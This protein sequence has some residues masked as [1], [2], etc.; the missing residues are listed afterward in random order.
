MDIIINGGGGVGEA[1]ADILS[2]EGHDV[3]I[4]ERDPGRSDALEELL[5]CQIINAT[6]SSPQELVRAKAGR[7]DIFLAVTDLDEV[8]LLSC[9]LARQ[10]GAGRSFARVSDPTYT[11]GDW[12]GRL[13]ELGIGQVINPEQ[14]AA[15]ET[16]RLLKTP[17]TTQLIPLAS[18]SVISAA[19]LV[20]EN[21]PLSGQT[22]SDLHAEHEHLRYRV[23]VIRRGNE[24][25]IPTGRDHVEAN[26]E[27]FFVA[28]EDT[29]RKLAAL[30][31]NKPD[32]GKINRVMVFGASDLG[33]HVAQLLQETFNVTLVDPLGHEAEDTSEQ[34]ARTLVIKGAGHEMDLLERVGLG[35][36]DAMVAVGDQ[37]EMNLIS[38]LYARRLGVRRTIARIERPFYRPL[39]TTVGV[40]A[41]VSARQ[42]TVNAILKYVRSGDIKAVARMRG[43]KAEALELVPGPQAKLIDVPLRQARFP[44][45]ALVAV[46]T[47][48]GEVIIPDG[49][50]RIRRGDHV[51]VFALEHVIR[52]VEKLFASER[53]S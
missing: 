22:L 5:D 33:R 34:L 41:A 43:I 53:G 4:I 11:A 1:L 37:E 20:P 18:G 8:N 51:V 47:R 2:L 16:V 25:I 29:I 12:P 7:C 50:T 27:L 31:T 38:C 3:T 23:V 13:S 28:Q 9:I 24:T 15:R 36:M 39:M 30:V 19:V 14:E 35:E 52:K 6:G 42:A 10:M 32:A 26:D 40:D 46:V 48:P 45:G 17:G 44:R 49:D 21:S